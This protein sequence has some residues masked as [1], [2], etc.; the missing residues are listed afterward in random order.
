MW[1]VDWLQDVDTIIKRLPYLD[2]VFTTTGVSESTKVIKGTNTT[3]VYFPNMC[4]S[5]IDTYKAFKEKTVYDIFYAGRYDNERSNLV[6]ILQILSERYKV[7]LFGLNKNSILLGSDFI[8]N[9]G[10]SKIAINYSRKN[11]I[12]LYS[13]DRIIQLTANGALVF[14]PKIPDF[15]KVF[16]TEEVVYFNDL[17]D[18]TDKLFF[19]LSNDDIR[20]KIA[21]AGYNRAHNSYDSELVTR[22]MIE[23]IFNIPYSKRYGWEDE[24]IKE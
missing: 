16:T 20:I 7:G 23:T 5:S 9:I 3:L 17:D 24:I 10:E 11:N 12:S 15:E 6:D 2:V 1:W 19:Y 18:L 4:D 21:Q 13:S 14:T 8:K 22:F